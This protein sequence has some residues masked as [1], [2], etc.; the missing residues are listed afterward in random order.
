MWNNLRI[1]VLNGFNYQPQS[2]V[3]SAYT[4][5]AM[6]KMVQH[7]TPFSPTYSLLLEYV[8]ADLWNTSLSLG[9]SS[10]FLVSTKCDVIF[11]GPGH[12][13]GFPNG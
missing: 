1:N 3:S 5:R 2:Q 7:N 13:P 6:Q 12:L 9:L 4:I 8:Y 10:D 11:W